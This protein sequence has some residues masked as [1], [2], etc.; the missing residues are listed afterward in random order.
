MSIKQSRIHPKY[1]AGNWPPYDRSFV[2]RGDVTLWLTP[3]TIKNWCPKPSDRRGA[4]KKFSDLAIETALTLRPV[5]NL[6]LRQ[7]EGFVRSI[8]HIMGLELGSP[9]HTTLSRRGQ[10][11]RI[12]LNRIRT[13]EPIHGVVTR[14]A[15]DHKVDTW[16]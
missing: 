15:N 11:L 5:F 16:S 2:K 1:R 14:I 10:D 13:S 9:N 6:P 12:S 7:A 4:Q 8:F 3:E